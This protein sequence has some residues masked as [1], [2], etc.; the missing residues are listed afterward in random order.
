MDPRQI[1]ILCMF[2]V[3]PDPRAYYAVGCAV[4]LSRP[5]HG[6]MKYV[7]AIVEL[8]SAHT[9]ANLTQVSYFGRTIKQRGVPFS[10]PVDEK[11]C[12]KLNL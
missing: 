2:V 5:L 1:L 10:R 3:Y 6:H 7:L 9:S 4:A 11:L 8:V 12:D